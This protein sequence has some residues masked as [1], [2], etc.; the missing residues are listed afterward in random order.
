MAPFDRLYDFLLVGHCKYSSILYRFE[1]FDVEKYRVLEIWVRGHSWSFKLVLFESLGAVS[2][3]PS[4]VTMAL[5]CIIFQTKRD[6]DRK[7]WF[8]HSSLHSTP[9]LGGFPSEYCHPAWYGT[10]IALELPD[11]EKKLEDMFSGVDRIPACNR[12]TDRQTDGQTGGRT[13]RQTDILR[14]HSPLYAHASH[15]EN[16]QSY[17]MS[18]LYYFFVKQC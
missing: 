4:I 1:L 10:T 15:G 7:S 13:D 9:P 5:S 2:Y 8:F 6:I 3:S 14:R 11:C 12:Q 16:W 18:L 17:A